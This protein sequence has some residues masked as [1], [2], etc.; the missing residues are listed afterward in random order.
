MVT[1]PKK[2]MIRNDEYAATLKVLGKTYLG[3]GANVWDAVDNLA[4]GNVK[5]KAII[6]ITHNGVTRERILMPRATMRL[7]NTAGLSRQV[8]LKNISVLFGGL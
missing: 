7:F 4:P 3:K 5:G 6:S 2:K 8:A 1:K